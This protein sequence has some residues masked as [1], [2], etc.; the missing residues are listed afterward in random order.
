V[1][2]SYVRLQRLLLNST[3]VLLGASANS[4]EPLLLYMSASFFCLAA[5]A[6]AAAARKRFQM[7]AQQL[8]WKSRVTARESSTCIAHCSSLALAAK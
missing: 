4:T 5:A 2:T 1:P 6:A 8:P 3:T 7:Q